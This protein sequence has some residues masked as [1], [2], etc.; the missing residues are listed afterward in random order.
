M[1]TRTD[2]NKLVSDTAEPTRVKARLRVKLFYCAL[3]ILATVTIHA[4]QQQDDPVDNL[5][6]QIHRMELIDRDPA[7]PSEVR[8]LN[9]DFLNKRRLELKALLANRIN[10]LQKYLANIGSSLT[11]E[12]RT[13]V[14]KSIQDLEASIQSLES[15]T[16][17]NGLSG[18]LG[19]GQSA[20]TVRP[21]S[22]N[23]VLDLAS[24]TDT[25]TTT[26]T[27]TVTTGTGTITTRTAPVRS[28]L[29]QAS[30]YADAPEVLVGQAKA[31]A[32]AIVDNKND[33]TQFF[34]FSPRLVFYA[35]ADAISQ[36]E[37]GNA[38]I[39]Q[40]KVQQFMEE[41][42]RTDKQIGASAT[43]EGSTSAAEKPGFAN[44]LGF[45]IENGAIQKNVN[46]TSLTLSSSPYAF[47]A[48]AN[49]DTSTTYQQYDF[50]NRI[51]VSANFNISNQD[52]VL[53]NVRRRQLAEWSIR[54]RLSKDQST[55]SQEFEEFWNDKIRK[56]FEQVPIILTGEF[57]QTFKNETEEIRRNTEE[58]FTS[59][60]GKKGFIKDY[61]DKNAS[62]TPDQKKLGLQQEILCHLKEE[63]FDKI[64]SGSIEVDDETRKRIV[65]RTI[66]ELVA[67]QLAEKGAV[68]EVNAKIKE[69]N[70]RPLATFAYTKKQATTGPNYSI[71]KF[72]YEKKTFS[73]MKIDANAGVSVYHGPDQKMNQQ[74]LR[75][76]AIAVSLEGNAGRSR[77][78]T[79]ELD[80]SQITFSFAGR[81][82]RMMENRHQPGRKADIAVAQF[83]LE[84]P[85]FTGVSLP[86]SVTFANATELI[87]EKHVRANF[88]FSFDADK[89]F[90]LAKLKKQ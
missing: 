38:L 82:Q 4:Q 83:K 78:L 71:F 35:Y 27:S 30:C 3:I 81:Y 69:M 74:S 57:A 11:P 70:N 20:D 47:V 89:L 44:L 68:D 2:Q 56:R 62:L 72:L 40:L 25:G 53:A 10:A 37:K 63:A 51:G 88:G 85:M 7:T 54:L 46:G 65:T 26:G 9:R 31:A 42:K 33:P 24:R 77:F 8:T 41:T 22:S 75:D 19:D 43:A 6:A 32:D 84:I 90:L 66:P 23:Q 48:A 64:K 52:N 5:K 28:S 34:G 86:F 29:P 18:S 45:A 80:Q 15:V 49:G 39:R 17:G 12:E 16:Q 61:L 36:G 67:A 1:T 50:L 59:L 55:R 60:D 58:K 87:K 13:T 14:E 79:T 73:P 21:A 76:F